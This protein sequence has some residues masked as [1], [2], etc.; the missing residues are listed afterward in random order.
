[1][2]LAKR[3]AT[4]AARLTTPPRV[5]PMRLEHLRIKLE[6]AADRLLLKRWLRQME[7][8]LRSL[9][10][11]LLQV[12]DIPG[13][14]LDRR[15]SSLVAAA[16]ELH[17]PFRNRALRLFRLRCGPPTGTFHDE[18]ANQRFLARLRALG[19]SPDPWLN[20]P[21]DHWVEG[22]NGRPLRLCFEK[23]PLEVL[24]MGEYF[25]TC[26]SPGSFNFFSALA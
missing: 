10:A 13:W 1:L 14:L 26:L 24:R 22:K 6:L 16:L 17:E 19:I 18:P 8:R 4:L 3:R 15:Y 25:Q 23:D 11:R 21:P 5:S 2:G 7:D 9:L 12:T 20:P